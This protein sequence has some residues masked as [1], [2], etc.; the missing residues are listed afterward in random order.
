VTQDTPMSIL[1]V[2]KKDAA[3]N[4]L[5][6][7]R[8]HFRDYTI[9]HRESGYTVNLHETNN[10]KCYS[11]HANG[12]RQLI[13]RRTPILQ[14]KPSRGE[15]GFKEQDDGPADPEFSFQRLMELN[16]KIRSYGNPDW[17]GM[18]HPENH[19]P[20]LGQAQGC[21]DCHDGK[22]RGILT[23]A[24][25]HDQVQK[26]ILLELSM[27]PDTDLPR[28]IERNEMQDPVLTLPEQRSLKKALEAH[29]DLLRDFEASRFTEL[30]K[31]FL[32]TSCR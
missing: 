19:G 23:V 16:K 30:K 27:P 31:W 17:N 1:V 26:K 10:G 14:S 22:T 25:S 29:E 7:V 20:A 2:Q 18:I 4:R 9:E 11:C 13:A 15:P 3:G 24:T 6:H 12:M 8:L 5:S 32:Q 28:W 21:I